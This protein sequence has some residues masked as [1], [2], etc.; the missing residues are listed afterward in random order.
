MESADGTYPQFVFPDPVPVPLPVP[1]PLRVSIESLIWLQ[2]RYPFQV[3]IDIDLRPK[4]ANPD[5]F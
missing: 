4:N 2:S 1:D 3:G 5:C